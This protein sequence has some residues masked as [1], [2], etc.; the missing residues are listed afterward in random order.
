MRN[1]LISILTLPLFFVASNVSACDDK[2]CEAAYI[3]SSQQYVSNHQRHAKAVRNEHKIYISNVERQLAAALNERRA[4]ALNRERR[5][6][7]LYHHIRQITPSK[8][9]KLTKKS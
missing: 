8:T 2:S 4:H 7:A 6:F 5:D 3:A 9:K 1:I